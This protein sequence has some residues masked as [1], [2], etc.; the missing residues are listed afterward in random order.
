[1]IRY[2]FLFAAFVQ[3]IKNME[4]VLKTFY[5][6]IEQALPLKMTRSRNGRAWKLVKRRRACSD[7][8]R[9]SAFY[10]QN[11]NVNC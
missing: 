9:F 8:A 4:S 5:I 3:V 2:V 6:A 7:L 1:M 11:L 10:F